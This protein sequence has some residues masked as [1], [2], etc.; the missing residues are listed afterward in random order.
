[1]KPGSACV[2]NRRTA[3]ALM[4]GIRRYALL[5]RFVFK[6]YRDPGLSGVEPCVRKLTH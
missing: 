1:M 5:L 6:K 4:D 3:T 2:R